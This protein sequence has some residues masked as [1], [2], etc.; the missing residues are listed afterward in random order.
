MNTRILQL[1]MLFALVATSGCSATRPWWLFPDKPDR[2]S[3]RTASMR[4]DAVREIAQQGTGLDDPEQRELT[5]QLARQIQI[6]PDPLVRESI[7]DAMGEFGTPMAGQVLQAGLSDADS[8]VRRKCCVAIGKRGEANSVELL[9]Q[10]L[11]SEPEHEV[12]I[13]AVDALGKIKSPESIKAL[14]VALEDSDPA[15]QFAGV[16]SLQSVTGRDYGG[17]VSAWLEYARGGEA[18]APEREPTSVAERIKGLS[19]F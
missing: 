7:I 10:V 16:R 15:M 13:A 18:I 19:P 9:A 2:T 4:M 5:D 1:L 12:R 3:Y 14:T 8:E 11:A 17:D 6:E